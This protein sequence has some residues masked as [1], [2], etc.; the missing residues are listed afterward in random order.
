MD[1]NHGEESSELF[2]AQ[3]HIYKHTFAFANSL[4][5]KCAIQLGIPDI[6]HN[7][8]HPITLPDLVTALQLPPAKTSYLHRLMRLLV[9]S[10][11]FATTKIHE[12]QEEEEEEGYVLTPSSKLLLKDELTSLST[13]VQAIVDPLLLSPWQVLGDWFRGNELTA[14]E[15]AHG[16]SLWDSV[17]KNPQLNK[18]LNDTM[19]S[20]S[21]SMRLALRSCKEIFGDLGSLVDVGGGTGTI[22]RII[23]EAFPHIK[24]TVLDLPHVVAN[25]PESENLK[26]VAGDMFLSIPPADGILIKSVLHNWGDEDCVKILKKCREAIPSKDDGGKVIIIDTVINGERDEHGMTEL[27]LV[28][29]IFM[30]VLVNGRQRNEKEWETL[31][32]EAGFSS[33]KITP[34]FG[35]RSLIEVY[36]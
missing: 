3:A 17:D 16:A 15:T 20:D 5:L 9:H 14:F 21:G 22:S 13:F 8:K 11:F 2:R 34:I 10:G 7:H 6:I 26:V 18:L 27:K 30:M 33:Y 4:C 28:F 1:P 12:N 31:F 32:L 25:L 29:D 36:P 35:I 23:L 19:E 24:C